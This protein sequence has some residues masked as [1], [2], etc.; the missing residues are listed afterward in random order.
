M[1]RENC[2]KGDLLISSAKKILKVLI[3]ANILKEM[4]PE[5]SLL[6]KPVLTRRGALLEV[7]YHYAEQIDTTMFHLR[8]NIKMQCQMILRE[9]FPVV[10]V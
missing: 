5:I 10:Q 3:I 2:P 6:Q 1:V 7:V 9:H 8:W 4:Y